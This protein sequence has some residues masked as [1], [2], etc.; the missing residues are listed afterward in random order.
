MDLDRFKRLIWL[1]ALYL[2]SVLPLRFPLILNIE[3][4]NRCNLACEMC[5]RGMSGRP[6]SDMDWGF[7]ERLCAELR[8]VGP[9]QRIFLQK[10]GEPLLYKRLP[11]MIAL[12]RANRAA[13]NI[14]VITNGTLLTTTLFERLAKAGL[15]DLI[16]SIDAVERDG[17]R[18][19]K[20]ADMYE[21]VVANTEAALA[22]KRA[23]GLALPLIKVR[24]V[25]R[26]DAHGEVARFRE[27]WN[28]VAD[29]IDVTPYHTWL[30]AV[31]DRRS[32]SPKPRYPCSLLWYTGIINADGT[33]SPCCI[34]YSCRGVFGRVGEGGFGAIW[35]GRE[36]NSLRRRHLRAEYNKTAICG[37]CEYWQIK[38]DIGAW[39]CRKYHCG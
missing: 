30:G 29:A 36:L 10:D 1:R 8:S 38:E 33:V 39:L 21:T 3:P 5:P 23:R 27:R 20:G 7:F 17:Y 28:G 16:I 35:N 18:R 4:T 24:M 6:L 15:D 37:S 11:E 31:E 2:K 9:I 12:L 32:Y 34:D 25:E 14:T 13:K 22:I 19:L 26:N